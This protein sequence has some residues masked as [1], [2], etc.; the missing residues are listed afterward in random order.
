[1]RKM[2]IRFVLLLILMAVCLPVSAA[3]AFWGDSDYLVEINDTKLT[4]DDYRHWWSEWQDPGMEVP[5]SLDE[6]VDFMLLSQEA[7]D[8]QLTENP[9]YQKKLLV[10]LKVRAL[11][12][13]KGEEIDA[14][15]QIPPKSELWD[16]YLKE[17]TPLFNLQMIAVQAEEQANVISGF[18]DAG[19]P[20]EKLAESAGLKEIAEQVESTGPMRY[21]RIPESLR[22]AVM[23]L[24]KD[25][26]A[27]PVQFGHAWYFIKVVE[28]Q[29]GTEEDFES[30][31]Q[32]LIRK[33]LKRQEYELT[34]KLL[35][36]LMEQYGVIVDRDL[37]NTI[38]PEGP[39]AEDADKI[40]ITIGTFK[41]PVSFVY[42]SIQKTQET[43]GHAMRQAEA[44]EESKQR[45]VDDILV[46]TLTEKDALARH[47]EQVPPL[48]YVYDFYSQYRLVKEFEETVVRPAVKITDQDIE[49]YYAE[50]IAEFS[51]EGMIEFA[52]V[53]TNES[54]LARKISQQLKEG[55]DFFTIMEPISPAGVKI[56]KKPLGQLPTEI[57]AAIKP[58]GS[59]QVA[60]VADGINTHFI[61]VVRSVETQQIPLEV[62]RDM[63]QKSL[64]KSRFQDI[65][66]GYVKQLRERS[67]IKV[68]KDAWKSLRKQLQ[69]EN[70]N[71]ES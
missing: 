69:E 3:D 26:V 36:R 22:A 52:N 24:Q 29:E 20:F 61:K 37:I 12:Q 10:F 23:P 39:S 65:R 42:A 1:M 71:H 9:S 58:L 56:E 70:A 45:I 19:V 8:M 35:E 47:Y 18:K 46:Q 32:A 4:E 17:Y 5:E 50:N 21:T 59:G 34:Q 14:N 40:A 62:V 44:F 48:K 6:Y 7:R 64:E 63:I 66:A 41:V 30:V 38:G 49:K 55:K 57:Q 16:A 67:A 15:K 13:L 43:R 60:T 11:M 31:K 68:N 51:R 33:S 28:R 27:G 25:Q 53:T 2:E 54:E